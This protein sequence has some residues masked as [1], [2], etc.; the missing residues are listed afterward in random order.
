MGSAAE[1]AWIS[2]GALAIAASAL[3]L[4]GGTSLGP[5]VAIGA[6]TLVVTA[7]AVGLRAGPIGLWAA[8]YLGC[9]AGLTVWSGLSVLWSS[10]PSSSWQFTNR[11]LVYLAFGALGV[12]YGR[13]APD[14]GRL[15]DAASLLIA[16]VLGWA[17]LA[18]VVPAIY[19]DY[20]R[21]ARLR[22]PV[23][24]WNVLA[25]LAVVAV[26][27]AL[28]LASDRSRR[29][30]LRAAGVALVYLA[31]LCVLLTYSRAGVFLAA[32]AAAAW[33]V[34]EHR[35]V[36][37]VVALVLG[38]LPAAGVFLYALTL[39]GITDDGVTRAGRSHDGWRFALVTVLAGLAVALAAAVLARASDRRRLSSQLEARLE[40]TI[41]WVVTAVG[42][43]AIVVF[44]VF[45]RRIWRDFEEAVQVTQ[46]PSHLRKLGSSNRWAWWQEAWHAFTRHPA[47]GTGSGTFDLTNQLT[48]TN[49]Y[50]VALEPHNVPLQFL[51]ETG[52][53]GLLLFLGAA[54]SASVGIVR[55]RLRTADAAIT[56]LGIGLAAWLCHLVVDIDW[57]FLAVTGPLLFVAGALLGAET[58]ATTEPA[59]PRLLPALGAVAIALVGIY[60]L[61]APWL[62]DRELDRSS[63]AATVNDS[64][65]HARRAHSLNPLSVDALL[66]WAAVEPSET[67][68]RQLYREALG[69]EP[70]NP[71]AWY[72]LGRWEYVRGN[73]GGAYLALDRSWG[74]DRLDGPLALRCSLLDRVRRVVKGYGPSCPPLPPG[75]LP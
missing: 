46:G 37:S 29:H 71:T 41:V 49:P 38:A 28:R 18:K 22:S 70:L 69:L 74:L 48:R 59:H 43:A 12:A 45:A 50:N 21:V 15:A 23:G 60:S 24:Y 75:A 4:S 40:R 33:L 51:S 13:V 25:I 11:L 10:E 73:L 66:Q 42:V 9:L 56:A 53:I 26:P 32:L 6:C 47:G 57:S 3:F 19:T 58:P 54:A 17:L 1:R 35:R 63:R 5:L 52:V 72:E 14:A 2:A 34:V 62:S 16:L 64:L 31:V 65:R 67:K 36:D 68:Q 7:V 30:V 39:P 44:A 61:A 27:L 55:A 20:E 8:S